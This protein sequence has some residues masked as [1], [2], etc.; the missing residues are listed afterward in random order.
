LGNWVSHWGNQK[1]A[2]NKNQGGNNIKMRGGGGSGHL[3]GSYQPH[4]RKNTP[5]LVDVAGEGKIEAI[6]GHSAQKKKKVAVV[7]VPLQHCWLG[8]EPHKK[9][10]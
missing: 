4:P 8:L 6:R 9:K 5:K 7:N 10:T 1:G 2:K 3:G